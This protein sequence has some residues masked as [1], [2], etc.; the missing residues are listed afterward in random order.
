MNTPE[1]MI[2]VYTAIRDGKAIQ[3]E[4]KGVWYDTSNEHPIVSQYRYRVKPEPKPDVVK[5]GIVDVSY[6]G[7]KERTTNSN[8]MYIFD[9]E[10]G[11]LKSAEVLR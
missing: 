8:V 6:H 1:E 10:T 11:E 5:Y 2:T 3:Y 7:Q 4:C 9:G